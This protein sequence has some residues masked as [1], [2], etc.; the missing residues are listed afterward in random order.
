LF[1]KEMNDP[2]LWNIYVPDN[3]QTSPYRPQPDFYWW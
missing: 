2:V 1:P 3:D